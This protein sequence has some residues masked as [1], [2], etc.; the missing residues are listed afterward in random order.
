MRGYRFLLFLKETILKESIILFTSFL[1]IFLL[2]N[3]SQAALYDWSTASPVITDEDSNGITT[4]GRDILSV[5]YASDNDYHYFRVDLE[6]APDAASYSSMY[7]ILIDSVEGGGS[8]FEST[9]LPAYINGVDY[10]LDSH[11]NPNQN[12]FSQSDFHIWDENTSLFSSESPDGV[13]QSYDQYTDQLEWMIEKSKIGTSFT[14]AA[15]THVDV[16]DF[17]I[18]YDITDM[19]TV[20][21]VPIP[22]AILLLGSGLL[23]FFGFS[24]KVKK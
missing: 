17:S 1:T 10:M 12:Y 24:R 2:A 3:N 11:Y 13:S 19:V 5:W 4:S 8:G 9:Y 18:T 6:S 15:A 16:N 22:G 7:S 14:F 20:N 21:P 23:G